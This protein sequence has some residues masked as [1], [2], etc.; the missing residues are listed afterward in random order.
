MP[1]LFSSV[2]RSLGR[3][4]SYM[5]QLF[6]S[7]YRSFCK[8][9]NLQD[10]DLKFSW[11]I[12]AVNIDNSAKFCKFSVPRNCISKNRVFPCFGSVIYRLD[13]LCQKNLFC[14][15]PLSLTHDKNVMI[16][17]SMVLEILG[18]GTTPP[19][20]LMGEGFILWTGGYGF[21]P[22]FWHIQNLYFYLWYKIETFQVV[23][24]AF[25]V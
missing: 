25:L 2:Y 23:R 16:I 13:Q 3:S 10:I 20:P 21:I 15:S 8:I 1:Q 12:S 14:A 19:M 6:A 7:I 17:L 11:L 22:L 5:P 18:G 24:L 9:A 4:L